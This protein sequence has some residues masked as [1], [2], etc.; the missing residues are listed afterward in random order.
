MSIQ[1]AILTLD[2]HRSCEYLLKPSS[3][4]KCE[5]AVVLCHGYGANHRDLISLTDHLDALKSC[6]TYSLNAPYDMSHLGMSS[7]RMWFYIEPYM[8][9]MISSA[10]SH[11]SYRYDVTDDYQ[12]SMDMLLKVIEKLISPYGRFVLMGFSQG[13]MMVA[14]LAV[15]MIK[16]SYL[17]S[18]SSSPSLSG[19]GV[20][21]TACFQKPFYEALDF[22]KARPLTVPSR[23]TPVFQS[24]GCHDQVILEQHS[25]YLHDRLR[26]VFPQATYHLADDAHTIAISHMIQLNKWLTDVISS[27]PPSS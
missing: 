6:D 20:L 14:D 10:Q 2:D 13:G 19:F 11:Q 1:S 23:Q 15:R 4:P 18:D 24:H 17:N 12:S 22:L 5:A 27:E 26:E 16:Q 9:Q 21:S 25:R 8:S 3:Q 7:A